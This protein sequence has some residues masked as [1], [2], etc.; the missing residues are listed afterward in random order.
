MPPADLVLQR[1]QLLVLELDDLPADNALEVVVVVVPPGVL[2]AGASPG[3][4]GLPDDPALHEQR[5]GAVD[6]G[7]GEGFPGAFQRLV[8][9]VC[10]EMPLGCNDSAEDRVPR[11]GEGETILPQEAAKMI[12]RVHM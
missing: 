12:G 11:L 5:E 9:L 7:G 2:V 3:T 4:E 8:Q 10:V 1:L 6:G